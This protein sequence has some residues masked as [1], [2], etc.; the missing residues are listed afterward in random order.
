MAMT[1]VVR[2]LA[3]SASRKRFSRLTVRRA[4]PAAPLSKPPLQRFP[5]PPVTCNLTSQK[6]LRNHG[7][8][9]DARSRNHCP[10]KLFVYVFRDLSYLERGF[11]KGFFANEVILKI[12]QKKYKDFA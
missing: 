9:R 5:H 2:D 10:P 7:R 12:R 11:C 1:L 6:N 8:G 4:A 3:I